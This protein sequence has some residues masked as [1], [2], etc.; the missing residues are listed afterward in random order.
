MKLEVGESCKM[1]S[2]YCSPSLIRIIKSRVVRWAGYVAVMERR[3]VHIGFWWEN[4]KE[5]DNYE[6]LDIDGMIIVRWTLER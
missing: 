2:L 1:R 6:D 3:G 4:R 5:R